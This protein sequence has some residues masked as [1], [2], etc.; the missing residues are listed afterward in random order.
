MSRTRKV[1]WIPLVALALLV[2]TGGAM[3]QLTTGN[4]YGQVRDDQGAALPGVTLTLSGPIATQ[5]QVSDDGGSFR[6]LNLAPGSYQLRAELEGFSSLEFPGIVIS[7][8]RNTTIPDVTLS[9]AIAETITVT[10]ETPVLD[11]RK[12]TSGISVTQTEL[13]SIPTARDP[14]SLL[15][16]TPGV[17]TDRINVGGNESGQQSVFVAPG[18]N[19][20]DTTWAVDGINI[21]DMTSIS[22]PSYFDFAAF[23]EVQF[24]T[25][26]SDVATESSGVT[27]NVVTK[28]GTNE[29]RGN[30]RY[31]LTDGDWQSDPEISNSEAGRN[32]GGVQDLSTFIPSRIDEVTEYGF[33]VG[34]PILRDRLWVWGAYGK[35]EIG[36]LVAGTGQLD[37]TELENSNLKL[38]AQ[39][40]ASN[41]ATVQYSEND[42]IKNGRGAGASR[43][44]A[45]TTDQSGVGGKP[46]DILKIE[47]SHVFSPNFFVTGAYSFV[48]SGFQLVPKGGLAGPSWQDAAGVYQ[49]SYYFLFNN[50]DITQYKL[51]ASVF[52][53]IADTSNELKFGA[54]HRLAETSSNFGLAGDAVSYSCIVKDCVGAQGPNTGY[55]N[56]WRQYNSVD[57]SEFDAM[58]LQDTVTAGNLTANIGVRYEKATGRNLPTTIPGVTIGGITFMPGIS[59]TEIDPEIEFSEIMPRLGLTYALGAER[60]TLLRASYSRFNE[61]YLSGNHTRLSSLGGNS[62]LAGCLYNDNNQNGFID[63]SE[64]ATLNPSS[65]FPLAFNPLNPTNTRTPNITDPDLEPAKTDELLV[66]VEHALLPEFVISASGLYRVVSDI[67]ELQ[68]LVRENGVV[69]RAEPG[70]YVERTSAGGL[71]YFAR[72]PGVTSGGGSILTNG[73]REQQA[74]GLTLAATKR[75]SNRWMARGHIQYTDWTWDVPNSYFDHVDPT[76][77][78]NAVG[79]IAS[80][81]RDGEVVAER[82]GGSGSKG[83]IWLNSEWSASLTGLY[84]VAPEQPWGFN[85]GAALNARQGYPNPLYTDIR[86]TDNVT[87]AVQVSPRIDSDRNDDVFTADLRVDKEFTFSDVGLS[88]GLDVFNLFNENTVLQ[89][90][91]NQGGSNANFI[92]ETISPRIL[93][94]GARL[95]FR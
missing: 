41:S 84:Q 86:G 37:A 6:F 42:K 13:E 22:S 19:S 53:P 95:S 39:L 92:T 94:V 21:T 58:W 62:I 28:R 3:A 68:L 93:R 83:G 8:N 40:G 52:F 27:V 35:T 16:Q 82:S 76:N 29:W 1:L 45:T 47:D 17:Q 63:G 44:P 87:R 4:L 18:S 34:G 10:T 43:A 88:V 31:L 81:D 71:Q 46:S 38:N 57:E 48:D 69:R 14:W 61:Q 75:L 11:E 89:R 59:S 72:R 67:T 26:G 33:D 55:V 70:D 25:G 64:A 60:K 74:L 9:T 65:C 5:V 80:G 36:N 73:D 2:T 24:I 7:A 51:D 77:L 79:G 85:V 90:E 54:S 32:P 56:L 12:I 15:T 91:R 20:D 30:G 78:G 23:E 50:R 49:G 66:G